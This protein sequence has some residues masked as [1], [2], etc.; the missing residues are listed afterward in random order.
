MKV[1]I[2]LGN[3]GKEYEQNRHNVG[4]MF[5]EYLAKKMQPETE[6]IL[7]PRFASRIAELSIGGEKYLFAEPQSYM[8][9]SGESFIKLVSFYKVDPESIFVA[10][11]DLDIPLGKT[12]VQKGTGPKLHGGLSSIEERFGSANFWRIRIGV[13]NRT[14]E[15]HI[16]GEA[17]VLQD[18]S[19]DEKD[20]LFPTFEKIH[21]QLLLS[22]ILSR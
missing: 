2:G 3:P 6:F 11:D 15:N 18:F 13:E 8:N 19:A 12:K 14:P 9:A 16:P 17:Y 20:L 1:F 5:V 10:H 22:K 7:Q 21:E 4:F